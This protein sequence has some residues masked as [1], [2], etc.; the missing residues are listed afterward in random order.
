MGHVVYERSLLY[1]HLVTDNT[2]GRNFAL[3][4][5]GSEFF[6]KKIGG[7]YMLFFGNKS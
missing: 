5:T 3:E 7:I 1:A 2:K 4:N 6:S